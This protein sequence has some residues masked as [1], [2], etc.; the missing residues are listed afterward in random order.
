MALR[1]CRAQDPNSGFSLVELVTVLVLLSILASVA[2]PRFLSL[3]TDAKVT[4]LNQLAGS[5]QTT[6]VMTRGLAVA[7]GLSVS[8]SNPGG[9]NAQ[10]RY[11]VEVGGRTSE[12]DWRNLCP[13]SEA[14]LGDSMTMLDFLDV[15]L[16]GGLSVQ[17]NNQYTLVGYDI[18]GGFSL[19]T[20]SG[21][22]LIYDSFGDPDCT[23]TVVTADC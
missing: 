11:I 23:V 20:T 18:P 17:T 8:A 12:I 7:A 9:G 1:C 4:V 15:S 22:Y 14:E 21:C 5:I 19:S 2:L 13:E 6:A 10:S 3:S 16:T